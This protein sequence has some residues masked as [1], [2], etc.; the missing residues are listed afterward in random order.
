MKKIIILLV[1]L[2]LSASLATA[3]SCSGTQTD[4]QVME[5][6]TIVITST[7]DSE[8]WAV[9]SGP[10]FYQDTAT[11]QSSSSSCEANFSAFKPG[12]YTVSDGGSDITV[13]VR[14]TFDPFGN[15]APYGHQ[16][17]AIDT[18]T[19]ADLKN[20]GD[21]IAAGNFLAGNILSLGRIHADQRITIGDYT[22]PQV[23]L[24]PFSS[25][26][27][28]TTIV[29]SL[30]VP[31]LILEGASSIISSN[32]QV[33][34]DDNLVVTG[35]L[36]G[37]S[38]NVL[39]VDSDLEVNSPYD[40]IVWGATN[41]HRVESI[42]NSEPIDV[43]ADLNVGGDI[44]VEDNITLGGV[45]R[46]T[47]P[48]GVDV[49]IENLVKNPGFEYGFDSYSRVDTGVELTFDS[50]TGEYAALL[51]S[52]NDNYVCL[53]SNRI[54]V[55][56]DTQYT[57]SWAYK[58]GQGQSSEPGQRWRQFDSSNDFI[59]DMTTSTSTADLGDGWIRSVY[60]GTTG[61]STAY[62]DLHVCWL[63]SASSGNTFVID[64]IQ[65]EGGDSASKFRPRFLDM[66][67][68]AEFNDLEVLGADLY[69]EGI[70]TADQA[71]IAGLTII[72]NGVDAAKV[73]VN[74]DVAVD[75]DVRTTSTSSRV[76]GS[77]NLRQACD[78]ASPRIY[79]EGDD[80][81]ISLGQAGTCN[82]DE[83]CVDG[84]DCASGD[85]NTEIN[86]CQQR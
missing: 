26:L 56:P 64:E 70:L 85:C 17:W 21:I 42:N 15:Y 43:N 31:S 41:L 16:C 71:S 10:S 8:N 84:T 79:Q 12:T 27:P 38:D 48:G 62:T 24:N 32:D 40:L 3:I 33:D 76:M 45:A 67:G 11:L 23:D 1:M 53:S 2:V 20:Y 34:I 66:T 30:T 9:T 14:D 81:V 74:G 51:T 25:V 69:T 18:S 5:G 78:S 75:G 72:G 7:G 80:L 86:L 4:Y 28:A 61:G 60:T 57:F 63:D 68:N 59:S 36:K 35:N 29:G 19:C 73:T 46:N 22:S 39:T 6:D 37:G 52:N 77:V 82:V 55:K 44:V 49:G 65:L 54:P 47:W 13:E 83:P 58:K 50:K